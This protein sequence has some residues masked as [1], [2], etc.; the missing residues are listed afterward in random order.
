MKGQQTPRIRIEPERDGTDGNGAAVLMEAYG[1][2]LDEWQRLIVDCWLGKDKA[3]QYTVTSAGLSVPRQNGKNVCIEARE[4]YGLTVN[5]E[6]IL[7]TAHQVRTAKKAFRRLANMFTD[8]KHPEIVKAVKKIRYGIG[9]ESIELNNGGI[10][11]FTARSRQAARGYDGISL[12]VYDEAQELTDDQAEAIMAV[13]SASATGT[14]QL[15][16]IGTPPY[17]GCTGEV[18]RRFRQA[19]ISSAGKGEPV[20]SSWHEWGI[21]ADTLQEISTDNKALWYEANPALGFRLTEEFTTEEYK[22]LSTDGF[23]RERLGWWAKPTE[24]VSELAIDAALWDKCRSDEEKPE[25][26]TAYGVKFSADGA[27]VVLA[28]AV[29]PKGINTTP[30]LIGTDRTGRPKNPQERIQSAEKARI[31]LIAIE[32]TGNG[33]QWL[34]DWLNERYKQASCVVIDGKNGADVLIDK[35]K[36]AGGGAWAF[37]DSIIKPSAQNVITA[38]QG[39]INDLH[40]NAVTW[41]SGQ[42]ELRDSAITATKRPISGGWGF[43]GQTCAPIEACSLALWGCRTSKRNPQRK[44]LIG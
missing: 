41:Y 6:R 29:I 38:A 9:E 3:G 18:F 10:I 16:Y 8:K 19:C 44:M 24:S 30:A 11:E 40:E 15:L 17:I 35:L 22:T 25:G 33:L 4:F 2:T 14:R 21:A 5:G 32:P 13:L 28:G 12:V 23:A 37:K 7:H 27:E 20:K 42:D 34:A 26:K 1:V 39:L 43:G 31:S 36:P